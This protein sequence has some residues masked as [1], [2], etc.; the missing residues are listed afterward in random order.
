MN[1][2]HVQFL[3]RFSI[4][5]RERSTLPPDVCQ[6]LPENVRRPGCAPP[7]RRGPDGTAAPAPRGTHPKE[8]RMLSFRTRRPRPAGR[9]APARRGLEVERLE[10]RDCPAGGPGF[11]LTVQAF[12]MRPGSVW[13]RGTVTAPSPETCTVHLDGIVHDTVAVN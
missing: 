5:N 13:V 9:P 7:R 1:G 8:V 12:A 3:S 11:S 10:A 2:F 6:R 4:L